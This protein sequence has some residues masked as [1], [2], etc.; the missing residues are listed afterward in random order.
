MPYEMTEWDDEELS[1]EELRDAQSVRTDAANADA[2]ALACPRS[3]RYVAEWEVWIAWDGKRWHLPGG[4]AG[5]RDAV[6]SVIVRT[7]R[8][9]Y[10]ATL[11]ALRELEAAGALLLTQGAAPEALEA[12]ARA[13]K[14]Q[15]RLLMWLEQSQNVG[16]VNACEALLRG[17]LG[18]ACADLDAKPWL[19]NCANGTVNLRTGELEPH[20]REDMLT[21]LTPIEYDLDAKADTWKAFLLTAMGGDGLLVA[22]L[23]RLLGYTLTGT[24]QEH[25]LVFHYGATGSNGKSTFLATIRALL[26]EYACSAPRGLLFEPRSGAEPHPTELARLHGRRLAT[27]AEVPEGVELAEAKIKDLTGGDTLAVRR[28]N[29][30]FWD[31]V[32]THTLHCAGNHKPVV[33]GT[34]GGIWRRIKLVPWVVTIAADQQDKKLGEK[35]RAELPGI[36]TW[37]VIGCLDWQRSGLCEPEPV[38]NAGAEY[39]SESD[40]LAAFLSAQCVFEPTARESCKAIRKAY[41]EWCE[42][43]GHRPLGARGLWRRCRELGARSLTVRHEGRAVDGLAGLRLRTEREHALEAYQAERASV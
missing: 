22:Y 2:V 19:L 11:V 32:P 16:R 1:D 28:M 25:L 18:V 14:S 23:Q 5:A 4:K 27:C 10:A 42:D 37:A 29:E 7:A 17:M 33:R 39:R 43:L 9:R 35:L 13:V 40:A 20:D 34:D 24:T 3:M 30:N 38:T 26:G 31:L 36:L 12:N 41:E 15:N 8:V 6:L 21:Q